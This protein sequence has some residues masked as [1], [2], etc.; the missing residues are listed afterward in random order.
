[1]RIRAA[2]AF[3][4]LLLSAA[5]GSVRAAGPARSPGWDASRYMD[6]DE[7]KPGMKG[8]GRS[9][10]QGTDIQEFGVE[11]LGVMPT[12]T[13]HGEM[14]LA[15]ISGQGLEKAGVIA[16]MSGSP[17]Y[18]DGRL[19]G[20]LAYGW[21]FSSDPITGITPIRNMLEIGDR[22]A[23]PPG[24]GRAEG[25]TAPDSWRKLLAAR[26]DE[27]LDVLAGPGSGPSAGDL[28][29]LRV[30]VAVSGFSGRAGSQA[31]DLLDRLGFLPVAGGAVGADSA[32]DH[33]PLEPGSAVGVE[34]VRGDAQIAAIGTVTWTDGARVLAFGHPMMDRGPSAY[35]M[36]PARIITVLPRLSISFK[37]GVVGA[38][39]GAITRDYQSGVMGE[40]GAAPKMIPV[41]VDLA[42]GDR[43]VKLH[44]EVL[45][46]EGLT[47]A[48]AGVV[49]SNGMESLGWA[50][51]SNT[52][53][54]RTTVRLADGRSVTSH[55]TI[56]GFAPPTSFAGEVARLV[57]LVYGNPFETVTLSGVDVQATVTDSI[58]A[59][60]L[61]R[62]SLDSGPHTPG[63]PLGVT[64]WFRDFRGATRPYH[65]AITLPRDLAPGAYR[66][67]VCDG[68]GDGQLEEARAPGRFDPE[69][70]D[71]LLRML[72]SATPY[73]TL[74]LRVLDAGTKDPVVAGRELPGLPASLKSAVAS[75]LTTGRV[76]QTGA[77]MVAVR[78]ETLDKMLLGCQSLSFNVEASR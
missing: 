31:E 21:P 27:A 66:L 76:T 32:S 24:G 68:Q 28:R 18:V 69:S 22:R 33:A 46:A 73:N 20:A 23:A 70:L 44:F 9:V 55:N 36:T 78:R 11:I 41:N 35:P 65:T 72:S 1:M 25:A 49:A 51:G 45:D 71:E 40:L 2:F 57:G 12:S 8:T 26:D 17:I 56:A 63:S 58:R 15:R 77:G 67:F 48:L 62:L 52:L 59:A 60:F 38:P 13:P 64:V 6:L 14:I 53:R 47:P 42:F 16:G 30:P 10:F 54:V 61:D 75:P 74:V 39:V 5:A 43:A 37:M 7:I 3:L 29:P 4:V 50:S 19:I 34:L